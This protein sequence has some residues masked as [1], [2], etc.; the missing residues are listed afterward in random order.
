MEN[1]NKKELQQIAF[2]H[3]SNIDLEDLMIL[4]KMCIAKPY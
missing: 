1:P 2:N 4:Y 3:L